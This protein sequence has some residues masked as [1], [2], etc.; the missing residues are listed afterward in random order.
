[1]VRDS[2]KNTEKEKFFLLTTFTDTV[3]G[4]KIH[5]FCFCCFCE[6]YK[7]SSGILYPHHGKNIYTPENIYLI[8][9]M[10]LFIHLDSSG[11]SCS[12]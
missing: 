2:V 12:D 11:M 9:A 6:D 10:A 5:Q 1:M 8:L 7:F 3:G 4:A